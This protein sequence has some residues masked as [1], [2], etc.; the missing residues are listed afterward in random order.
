MSRSTS[1]YGQ[2]DREYS[3]TCATLAGFN[4]CALTE[5]EELDTIVVLKC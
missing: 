5:K 4:I 3:R 1:S 2:K